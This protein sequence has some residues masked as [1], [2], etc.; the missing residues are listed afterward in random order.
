MKI[1]SI[2]K[3]FGEKYPNLND[4][5]EDVGNSCPSITKKIGF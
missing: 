3:R 2:V 4:I 5:F 1:G